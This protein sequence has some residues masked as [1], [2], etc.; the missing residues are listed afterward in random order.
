MSQ[1]FFTGENAFSVFFSSDFFLLVLL[2]GLS[3]FLIIHK[4]GTLINGKGTYNCCRAKLGL[5]LLHW[6]GTGTL[7]QELYVCMKMHVVYAL[8]TRHAS[9]PDYGA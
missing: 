5:S 9:D 1:A 2:A 3:Y 4:P 6:S 8:G 7:H